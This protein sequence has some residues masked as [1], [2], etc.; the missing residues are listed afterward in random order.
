[1]HNGMGVEEDRRKGGERY[2]GVGRKGGREGKGR[3]DGGVDRER[4]GVAEEVGEDRRSNQHYTVKNST[5]VSPLPC[6]PS[7]LCS[8]VISTFIN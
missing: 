8:L 2:E 1:M 6:L 3:E 5:A 4:G 7:V